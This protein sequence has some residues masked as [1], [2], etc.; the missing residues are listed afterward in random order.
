M[1]WNV[2]RGPGCFTRVDEKLDALEKLIGNGRWA[3]HWLKNSGFL[4]W[5]S[6]WRTWVWWEVRPFRVGNPDH[7]GLLSRCAGG[8]SGLS[9]VRGI[10]NGSLA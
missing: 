1:G 3:V 10:A 4:A 7:G 6:L 8:G 5:F 2:P 9:G